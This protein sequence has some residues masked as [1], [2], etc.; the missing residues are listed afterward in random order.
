[1]PR[2]DVR[3]SVRHSITSHVPSPWC[4]KANG[5]LPYD[6]Q[7]DNR[8]RSR[9]VRNSPARSTRL[10]YKKPTPR[11]I[12]A[13]L[14]LLEALPETCRYGADISPSPPTRRAGSTGSRRRRRYFVPRNWSGAKPIG[15]SPSSIYLYPK[16]TDQRGI[17]R[18][19]QI[20]RCLYTSK[21]K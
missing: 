13:A 11:L 21:R 18:S 15:S 12:A 6:R 3:R 1:M 10:V 9:A 7:G 16:P 17:P 8:Q 20:M 14:D 2:S 5:R 19:A 4:S